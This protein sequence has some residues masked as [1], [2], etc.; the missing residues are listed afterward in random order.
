MLLDAYGLP[1]QPPRTAQVINLAAALCAPATV[2]DPADMLRSIGTSAPNL[3]SRLHA[4]IELAALLDRRNDA[5]G[6][7]RVLR[8]AEQLCDGDEPVLFAR[9][10]IRLRVA[11]DPAEILRQTF[12]PITNGE[13]A[14]FKLLPQDLTQVELG[15]ALGLSVN[16]IKSHLRSL[17]QKIGVSTRAEALDFGRRTGVLA[18]AT[19]WE[20]PLAVS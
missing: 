16:T 2:G 14:V 5:R 8:E 9:R 15:E 11:I 17:Y 13:R 1:A 19:P 12:V 6:S 18:T 4:L 3:E 10:L 7:L 20:D